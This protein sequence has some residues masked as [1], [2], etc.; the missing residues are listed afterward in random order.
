MTAGRRDTVL[1]VTQVTETPEFSCD[2]IGLAS[3]LEELTRKAPVAVILQPG[4]KAVFIAN[5]P[6]SSDIVIRDL[7]CNQPPEVPEETVGNVPRFLTTPEAVSDIPTETV[8]T[9][10]SP[11][12][13][14]FLLTPAMRCDLPP[15]F[16]LSQNVQRQ[17]ARVLNKLQ[18]QTSGTDLNPALINWLNENLPKIIEKALD[19]HFKK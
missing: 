12:E 10:A 15:N 19:N 8:K 6:E 16:E 2:L 11:T 1:N 5:L 14:Y 3:I 17:T 9:T 13:D 18:Q 4:G 7:V